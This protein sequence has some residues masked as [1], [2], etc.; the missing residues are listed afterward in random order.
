MTKHLFFFR[1]CPTACPNFSGAAPPNPPSFPNNLEH[2]FRWK[3]KTMK[4]RQSLL[5]YA[6]NKQTTPKTTYPTLQERLFH[7]E[8]GADNVS[9]RNVNQSEK[10]IENR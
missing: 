2:F 7:I 4:T 3:G 6:M 8:R 5:D 9:H 10:T 1:T